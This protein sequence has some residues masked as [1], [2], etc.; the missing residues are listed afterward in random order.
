MKKLITLLTSLALIACMYPASVVRAEDVPP[1]SNTDYW[2]NYCSDTNNNSLDACAAY[3]NYLKDQKSSLADQLNDAKAK[4]EQYA[5]NAAAYRDEVA[6]LQTEINALQAQIADVQTKIDDLQAQID[7][8]QKA[9]DDKQ[10]EIDA[11]QKQIDT[12]SDK[13]K[14]RMVNQ[15]NSL[16]INKYLD[17][18]VGASTL[19]DWLRIVSGLQAISD[20]DKN[21]SDQLVTLRETQDKQKAEFVTAQD[22]LKKSQAEMQ[23]QKDALASSQSDL[24]VKQEEAKAAAE[25]AEQLTT[26]QLALE[27]NISSNMDSIRDAL[28]TIDIS[29]LPEVSAGWTYPAPGSY[30]SAGTWTYYNSDT[31]HLGNDFASVDGQVGLTLYAA[32]NG[33]VLNS[34][35]GCGYGS[36]GDGCGRAQ[37]GLWGGGNQ[38]YLLCVV[39]DGLYAVLYAHML[40]NTPIPTGTVVQGGDQIGNMGSSGNST[41]P[42]THV[43]VTYLG[44]SS[45]F[46]TWRANWNGDLGFG[47][48]WAGSYDGYGR[49]CE[50]GYSAPCRIRPESVFG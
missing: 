30:R 18:L 27:D 38:I 20:S 43:E 33:I 2:G 21:S 19:Q 49:R 28:H 37:G 25:A 23:T 44:A 12:I 47:C 24:M 9:I 34:V 41:G 10:K 13:I 48:G 46:T 32:A 4:R 1:Y 50:A 8:K 40:L 42:H 16:K 31:I 22:E 11:T 35:N 7:V 14:K 6:N 3:R 15:Q 39:G 26:Q 36:L 29:G 45:D 5:A 17:I